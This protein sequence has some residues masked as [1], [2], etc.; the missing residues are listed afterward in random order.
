MT[1]LSVHYTVGN[2]I[3]EAMRAHS[4]ISKA[5]GAR[6][7][8]RDAARGRHSRPE[9]RIDAYPFQLSGGLRQ[10]VEHRAGARRRSAES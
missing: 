9:T 5:R 1:A 6:A 7:R 2:Q 8:G 3:I 10:R 4:D